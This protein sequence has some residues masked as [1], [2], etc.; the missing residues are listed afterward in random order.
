MTPT[1]THLRG[2]GYVTIIRYPGDPLPAWLRPR[3]PTIR[4]IRAQ[5][6]AEMALVDAPDIFGEDPTLPDY[7]ERT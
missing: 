6:L 5:A 1:T 4:F 3:Q 7:E 2:G